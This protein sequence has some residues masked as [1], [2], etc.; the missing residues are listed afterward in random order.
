ME[1]MGVLT[2][3]ATRR[4]Y[5]GQMK[6]NF[7]HGIGSFIWADGTIYQGGFLRDKRFGFGILHLK[8]GSQF[9]GEWLDDMKHGPGVT[10]ENGEIIEC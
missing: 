9:E 3:P 1:G 4:R 7:R 10:K 5:E 8:N 2:W 6:G